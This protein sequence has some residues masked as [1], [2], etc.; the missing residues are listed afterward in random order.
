MD[1]KRGQSLYRSVLHADNWG[2]VWENIPVN[3]KTITPAWIRPVRFAAKA[4]HAPLGAGR[5]RRFERRWFNWWMDPLRA[6]AAVTYVHAARESRGARHAVAF[7]AERYLARHSLG[8]N[9]V[10]A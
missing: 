9:D 1:L 7:V 5:W 6:S 10:G 3:A 2:G 8:L 4:A